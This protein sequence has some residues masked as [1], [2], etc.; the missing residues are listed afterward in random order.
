MVSEHLE[1]ES[2][3]RAVFFRGPGSEETAAVE[4]ER[5]EREME[6]LFASSDVDAG[7]RANAVDTICR[8]LGISEEKEDRNAHSLLSFFTS[9]RLT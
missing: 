9:L 1:S 6:Q 3:L 4:A 7:F 2:L 5:A 8:D